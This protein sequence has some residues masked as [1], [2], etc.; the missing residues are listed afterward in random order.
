MKKNV[1]G[2]L[3]IFFVTV[4]FLLMLDDISKAKNPQLDHSTD[5]YN[6]DEQ[7]NIAITDQAE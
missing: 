5:I 2:A 3:V 1:L 7:P 4:A 6:L